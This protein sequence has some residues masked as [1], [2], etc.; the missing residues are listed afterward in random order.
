VF[1]ACE[2]L[3][4]S[5]CCSLEVLPGSERRRTWYKSE[6]DPRPNCKASTKEV[7]DCSCRCRALI[8]RDRIRQACAC[9]SAHAYGAV[10]LGCFLFSR[11]L[12]VHIY[13]SCYCSGRC[14]PPLRWTAPGFSA[15]NVER[16]KRARRKACEDQ[17]SPL[18]DDRVVMLTVV[19]LRRRRLN[20]GVVEVKDVAPECPRS[21]R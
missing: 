18:H 13:S 21:W 11:N 20:N 6:I 15:E 1:D 14:M 4:A 3:K 8:S 17:I 19:N 10:C 16:R 7:Q 5:A 9:C 12:A 2:H